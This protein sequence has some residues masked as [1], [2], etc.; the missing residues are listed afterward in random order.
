MAIAR[1]SGACHVVYVDDVVEAVWAAVVSSGSVHG[2]H[3]V[4]GPAPLT[5]QELYDAFEP[6]V[7]RPATAVF[8]DR[9]VDALARLDPDVRNA[10]RWPP[11]PGL[12]T[13]VVQGVGRRL[14]PGS[15][16]V[17]LNRWLVVP[18]PEV[19]AARAADVSIPLERTA[20][21]L[22]WTPRVD[23]EE[24]MRRTAAYLRWSDPRERG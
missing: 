19:L 13:R 8:P 9:E 7:G 24:G 22:G 10:L 11:L 20:A 17:P 1:G 14:V 4:T 23:F 15:F 6:I 21:T 16:P 3:L 5:W 18:P 12:A 2:R